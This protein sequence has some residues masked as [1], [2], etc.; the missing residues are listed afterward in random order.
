[1]FDWQDLRYFLTAARLGSLAAAATELRVDH[2][3]V[4]RRIARLEAAID[5]KLL[6]RLPRST[7]LTERGAALAEVAGRMA[8]DAEAVV[9]HLR[10]Q[11]DGLSGT[12]TVSTLP[13]LAAF[14]IAPRL[15]ELSAR[16]PGIR[17]ILSTTTAIASLE[18]GDADIAIGFVQPDLA[19]RVV[20]QIA[21]LPF[22]LY[23]APALAARPP[24]SWAFIGFEDSLAE[25]AQQKWLNRF[26]AGRP[27]ALRSN[28]VVTQA[29]GARAGLGAALLPCFV[30]DCE[31][32]LVRLDAELPP[33]IRALWMSVHAD[34]RRS[35]AVRA[36]M[37]HVI[38]IFADYP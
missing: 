13:A 4:G 8:N 11:Q 3:T 25:I 6:V 2:A 5:V 33:P 22:S 24:E 9:R 27:F 10:A 32:A 23:G 36:V 30:G 18:R 15:P 19:G 37:D 28:D 35:H 31:P 38:G 20:R 7:R 26:S 34:V 16:H 29:Q 12:V 1:M 14:V 21:K 17:L